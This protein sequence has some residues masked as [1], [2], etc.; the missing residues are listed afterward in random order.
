MNEQCSLSIKCTW[1]KTSWY[2]GSCDKNNYWIKSPVIQKKKLTREV[3]VLTTKKIR[4]E[5]S[6]LEAERGLKY[7]T[8]VINSLESTK[9]VLNKEI[10]GLT[11]I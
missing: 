10:L 9:T 3:D 5:E 11:G 1:S 7:N 4:L 2:I 8:S 6:N